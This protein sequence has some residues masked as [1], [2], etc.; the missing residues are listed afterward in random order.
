MSARASGQTGKTRLRLTAHITQRDIDNGIRGDPAHCPAARAL[1]RAA[2]KAGLLIDAVYVN[3]DDGIIYIA[4]P[5]GFGY[6]HSVV[7]KPMRPNMVD[8]WISRFDRGLSVKPMQ[9]TFVETERIGQ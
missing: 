5:R 7:V 1:R 3:G 2:V 8:E 9:I 6:W 4:D